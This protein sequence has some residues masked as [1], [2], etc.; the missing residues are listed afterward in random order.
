MMKKNILL[1]LKKT[2]ALMICIGITIAFASCNDKPERD[3][4]NMENVSKVYIVQPEIA[5]RLYPA[6]YDVEMAKEKELSNTSI[7]EDRFLLLQSGYRAI[8]NAFL[9]D[10][11]SLNKYQN[12]LDISDLSFPKSSRTE[13]SEI[14]AFGRNNIYIRNTLFVERLSNE[15]IKL[16]FDAIDGETIKIDNALL[17]MVERTWKEI[18]VVQLD[19]D[20][21]NESYEIVYDEDGINK[22][23]AFN[24]SLVL[25][26]AYDVEFDSMGNILNK[27][28]EKAKCEYATDL[29]N[30]MEAEISDKL[31]CH[32]AVIIKG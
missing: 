32:V 21:P 19:Q 1:I 22:I 29:A 23:S 2:I 28:N 3:E 27:E 17:S 4:F 6:D 20:E 31:S 13:Y 9:C 30:K 10:R 25:E 26:L 15:D 14:G 18:V 5:E 7:Y 12:S 8:F 24:D 16:I 11:A